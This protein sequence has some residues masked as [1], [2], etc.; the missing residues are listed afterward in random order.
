[1]QCL[2]GWKIGLKLL[3]FDKKASKGAF[4]HPLSFQ[5]YWSKMSHLSCFVKRS[6]SMCTISSHGPRAHSCTQN[7]KKTLSGQQTL[8]KEIHLFHYV[9]GP[10]H[11][12]QHQQITKN[13]HG[14][15]A[16]CPLLTSSLL[17]TFLST[18]FVTDRSQCCMYR[19]L[20]MLIVCSVKLAKIVFQGRFHFTRKQT[21]LHPVCSSW[22]SC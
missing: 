4:I 22:C 9:A 20:S 15:K 21:V 10:S 7:P 1:M 19:K 2:S 6:Q 18:M 16:P 12:K 8:R 11:F 17:H 5:L 3:R 14:F 13:H